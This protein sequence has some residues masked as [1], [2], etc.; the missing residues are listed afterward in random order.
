VHLL[1]GLLASLRAL[2]PDW[3][4]IV[5]GSDSDTNE[6]ELREAAAASCV[7]DAVR[8]AISPSD[9][10]LR[11]L[12]GEASWYASA[13]AH[14]GFGIAAVEAM[15][16]GLVPVLS[17][18][19]PFRRLVERT[20]IGMVGDF[21]APDALGVR[22]ERMAETLGAEARGA[23]MASVTGLDWLGVSKRY[24]L[25]YEAVLETRPAKQAA[26]AVSS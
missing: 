22:V 26:V 17:D 5:A 8:F 14:E 7:S 20:G 25:E 3:R 12:I 19:A 6:T 2:N 9:A 13:S 16:A 21:D 15:S 24:E 1:F 18:I 4:L 10:A 11:G 23:A